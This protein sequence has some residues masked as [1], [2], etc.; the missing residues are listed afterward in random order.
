M[1]P[2][3]GSFLLTIPIQT[4]EIRDVPVAVP[5]STAEVQTAE[6]ELAEKPVEKGEPAA[7]PAPADPVVSAKPTV[8]DSQGKPNSCISRLY[9]FSTK[10]ISR[11]CS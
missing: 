11:N 10:N 1:F 5:A 8:P 3:F 4:D 9:D 6:K 2:L 7:A